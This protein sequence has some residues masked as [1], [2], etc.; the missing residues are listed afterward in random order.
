MRRYGGRVYPRV[1]GETPVGAH[2]AIRRPGLSPRVR[3]N[4]VEPQRAVQIGGSIPACTGKPMLTHSSLLRG[5]VYP[6]VYGE[7]N[8]Q[9]GGGRAIWGLSP[10]VRGNH[11][12][13]IGAHDAERSIPACTGKP[14][15]LMPARSPSQV[16]P[17]VYGETVCP[18]GC[19]KPSKGLSPRVRG[20]PPRGA[21]PIPLV[22]SI[23]ACTGKPTHDVR[24]TTPARVYP[25]V[26]GETLDGLRSGEANRGLSPRVRGNR[27]GRVRV[28]DGEGS[29]PACTGKPLPGNR[30]RF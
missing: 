6:R 12:A 2:A 26:Y 8:H 3:G 15:P 16:Y 9:M 25:R 27:P 4:Q 10:R 11:R 28:R 17:R 23:P 13:G 21:N 30:P 1:Y 18:T 22:G 20:N 14:D 5:W 29:I 7:T 19:P 24:G